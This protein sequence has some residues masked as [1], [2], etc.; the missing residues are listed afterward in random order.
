[1][2]MWVHGTADEAV[3]RAGDDLLRLLCSSC[4]MQEGAEMLMSI[5]LQLP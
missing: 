5:G 2:R 1:M 4:Y 3:W